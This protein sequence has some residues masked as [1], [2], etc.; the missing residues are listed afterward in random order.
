MRRRGIRSAVARSP[1]VAIARRDELAPRPRDHVPGPAADAFALLFLPPALN[2]VY[3]ALYLPASILVLL[4]PARNS[5]SLIAPPPRLPPT[6]TTTSTTNAALM[7]RWTRRRRTTGGGPP[8]PCRR[9][10]CHPEQGGGGA[11]NTAHCNSRD[12]VAA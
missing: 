11:Q 4:T 6:A 3:P 5:V 2:L 10:P 9:R 1:A 12:H 8:S 7:P